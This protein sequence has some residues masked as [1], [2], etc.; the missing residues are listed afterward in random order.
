M[1]CLYSHSKTTQVLCVSPRLD[2]SWWATQAETTGWWR[3]G[4]W[5]CSSS[6][7]SITLVKSCK[8]STFVGKL[9]WHRT[10]AVWW[11]SW[12]RSAFKLKSSITRFTMSPCFITALS[13]QWRN[14]LVVFSSDEFSTCHLRE[15][16]RSRSAVSPASWLGSGLSPGWSHWGSEQW[17]TGSQWTKILL[18]WTLQSA[19]RLSSWVSKSSGGFTSRTWAWEA[20]LLPRALYLPSPENKK[21]QISFNAFI[22]KW[23]F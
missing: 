2:W 19:R 8:V 14:S 20:R 22:K 13:N 12:R 16:F 11:K 23:L 7:R 21:K 4:R 17:N 6:K 5:P 10:S 3:S 1:Y 18:R 15:H 9:E